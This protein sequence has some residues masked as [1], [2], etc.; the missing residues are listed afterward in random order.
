MADQT[1]APPPQ[2]YE[3]GWQA[4]YDGAGNLTGFWRPAALDDSRGARQSGVYDDFALEFLLVFSE[5]E[6]DAK[7]RQFHQP[8]FVDQNISTWCVESEGGVV[9]TQRVQ[10]IG[11]HS[12]HL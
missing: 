10:H 11:Q 12:S 5:L 6:R 1:F 9:N 3:G 2:S 8:V 4:H 7:V